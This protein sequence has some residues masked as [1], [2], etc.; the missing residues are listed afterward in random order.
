VKIDLP[1]WSRQKVEK[2]AFAHAWELALEYGHDPSEACIERL[3]VNMLRHE[4]TDYDADQGQE[5]KRRSCVAIAERFPWLAAECGRQI[6]QRRCE[7]AEAARWRE[8]AELMEQE[9]AQ[10]VAQRSRASRE[11][12]VRMPVGTKVLARV[13]GRER[14]GTIVWQ[15]RARVDVAY[16][17]KSGQER[18]RR[19]YATEVRV[20]EPR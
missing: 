1:D 15:G 4:F 14:A 9:R 11:A 10:R 5:A 12:I 19:L 7:E 20:A 13:A 16:T 8:M 17:L 6:D 3:V 2:R 18:T